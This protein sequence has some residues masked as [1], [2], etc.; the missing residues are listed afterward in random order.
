MPPARALRTSRRG[1]GSRTAAGPSAC[2]HLLPYYERAQSL[3]QLGPFAYAAADWRAHGVRP[4]AFRGERVQTH[5]FH[6][7]PPTRFGQVY[8]D[9]WKRAANVVTYLGANV[10]DLETMAPPDRVRAARVAC[11]SGSGFRV[12]AR[13]VHPRHRRNRE[14]AAPA[15]G[16][17][18][19][20]RRARERVT[21]WSAATSWSICTWTPRPR[22]GRGTE[23]SSGFYT[24]G[25]RSEG[26][27]VRGIL[28]L[29]PEL[30]RRERLDE[31]LRRS[32]RGVLGHRRPPSG[33]P[34]CPSCPARF[35][36][37]AA[38]S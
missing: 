35:P 19:A 32:R 36:R 1:T 6:Y 37:R 26:R 29:D 23:A 22:S 31:L 4:I 25:H 5:V 30:R 11:L 15:D 18:R 12:A 17:P 27:R 21:T 24:S 14:R 38:A 28:G 16:E 34:W 8:R 7:S 33:D 13:A 20:A 10:V 9:D 2:D 3:C